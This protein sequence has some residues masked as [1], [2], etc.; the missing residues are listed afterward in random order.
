ML[1]PEVFSRPNLIPGERFQYHRLRRMRCN[2]LL[3][4]NPYLRRRS[5]LVFELRSQGTSCWWLEPP[6]QLIHERCDQVALGVLR[7]FRRQFF[8][9]LPISSRRENS[10]RQSGSWDIQKCLY[11][12]NR[13][14]AFERLKGVNHLPE[15]KRFAVRTCS[16]F[17][18]WIS[19]S[20]DPS[21]SPGRIPAGERLMLFEI[22]KMRLTLH[23]KPT[24]NESSVGSRLNIS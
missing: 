1:T 14:S 13:K 6:T 5:L 2:R 24:K 22:G 7:Q 20:T 17:V 9:A 19:N 15:I 23:S 11:T 18:F 12:Q 3:H 21:S 8:G 16:K 4:Q 10:K